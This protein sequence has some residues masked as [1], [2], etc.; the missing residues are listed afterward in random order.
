[1]LMRQLHHAHTPASSCSRASF[2]LLA[3][4][5]HHAHAPAISCSRASLIMLARQLH[6]A[7]TPASSCSRAS[8]I[9]LAHQ[10]HLARTPASSCSHTSFIMLI[11]QLHLAGA[12]STIP[13]KSRSPDVGADGLIVRRKGGDTLSIASSVKGRKVRIRARVQLPNHYPAWWRVTME[14]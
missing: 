6:H 2:I 12:S 10:L 8:F 5:L 4:Q 9:M 14:Q 13:F 3:C 11:H 1:M 7:H